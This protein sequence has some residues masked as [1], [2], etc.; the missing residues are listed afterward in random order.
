MISNKIA[1][2][3]KE[4]SENSQQNSLEKVTIEHDKKIPEEIPKERCISIKERQK[5][6]GD[7]RL[8]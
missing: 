8:T 1:N 7:L 5:S 2:K 4:I 3:I 6:I